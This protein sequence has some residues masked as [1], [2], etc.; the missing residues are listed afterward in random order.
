MVQLRPQRLPTDSICCV[1][2]SIES[3]YKDGEWS[4][5]DWV[6]KNLHIPTRLHLERHNSNLRSPLHKNINKREKSN[7]HVAKKETELAIA[8]APS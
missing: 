3:C 7:Q 6:L 1:L 4:S 5:D 2:H 8:T